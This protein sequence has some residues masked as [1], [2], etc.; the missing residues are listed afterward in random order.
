MLLSVDV[1]SGLATSAYA[2]SPDLVWR[3]S[4]L[5]QASQSAAAV[6]QTAVCRLDGDLLRSKLAAASPEFTPEAARGAL[7]MTVPTPDGRFAR[8]AIA[9]SPIMEPGLAAQFPAIAT[10]CG[11]GIDDPTA[12][13][14]FDV[15][16]AGFHAQVLAPSGDYYVDP[17]GT[18]GSTYLSYFDT[19]ARGAIGAAEPV[20]T[21]TDADF[22]PGP[23]TI[24]APAVAVADAPALISGT[25]LRTYR[26]AVAA[27]GEY[28][29]FQGGTVAAAQAAIVT[30]INRVDGIYERELSVRLTLVANNS[31]LVYTN[32]ATDPYTN[33][34]ASALLGE[35]QT[36]VDQVIG[37]ANY[38]I[39]HVFSTAGGGLAG[40]GVVGR[41]GWKA[42]GET[43]LSSPVGDA[44]YVDYVAH[45]M[46]H[47]FGA[48]HTFNGVN[49]A[50][51]GNRNAGTAYEPGSG[52]TIMS[53]AGICDA[54]DLQPHS[55]D[56]F[57]FASLDE[58]VGY[59]DGSVP[60]VGT[61]TPTGNAIPTV[62][63]GLN[64]TIPARTPFALTASGND[65]NGDTLTY[66]WEERDLGAAQSLS[67]GDNG[68][69][70]ILRSY[71]PTTDPTRTFPQ[72]SDL[73]D[74]T[75]S[76]GERLPTTSRT[77]NFRVTVRDNRS[78]GGG[79]NADDMKVT[80][81][82]TGAAFAVTSPTTAVSWNTGTAHTVTWNVAGTTGG[83]INASQVDI[84]LSTD[85]GNTF[86]IV[87]AAGTANDGSES[88]AV[89]GMASTSTARIMVRPVGNVFFAMSAADFSIVSVVNHAPV[90]DNTGLMMLSPVVVNDANSSGTLVSSII[91][92]AGG[93]RI[94]DANLDALEGIAVTAADTSHGAWQ[95]SI[96][97]GATWL[98]LG[99]PSEGSARMLAADAGTKVRFIP[100]TDFTGT[101]DPGITFH[102]W[103]QTS[104]AN[105]AVIDA[106][107]NGG[108]TSLS[109]AA[110]T[111]SVAV[112][113]DIASPTATLFDPAGGGTIQNAAINSRKTI[114]IAFADA[115]GSGLNSA[116]IVDSAPEFTLGGA[117]AARVV[118]SGTPT[119]VSENV[120]RYAFTGAFGVGPVSVGFIADS[121]KD[122]A[123]NGNLA[124]SV[125]FSVQPTLSIN[126]IALKEGNSG[127]SRFNFTVT[128]SARSA[129][130]ITV[131]YATQ[132]LTA[133]AGDDYTDT[134]GTLTF[135]AGETK[136]TVTVAVR[137]DWRYE[138]PETFAV[139][140]SDATGAIIAQGS[141][142]GTIRNDDAAPRVSIGRVQVTE[143][144]SGTT[145]AVFT[146]TLS[147]AS[148]RT[149][150]VHYATANGT[151]SVAEGDYLAATGNVTIPAGVTGGTITVQVN[152]DTLY[153]ADETFKVSLSA[154]DGATIARGKGTGT[155][156]I[157]ADGDVMPEVSIAYDSLTTVA[158][159][160]R[161]KF[162]VA[163]SAPSGLS[164]TVHYATVND[165]AKAGKDFKSTTGNL[166][167][168]AGQFQMPLYVTILGNPS[169]K[170]G[171]DFFVTLSSPK[172]ATLGSS[173]GT[174]VFR[175]QAAAV[176]SLLDALAASQR[177]T[178]QT[179]PQQH[180]SA[181]DEAIR[182]LMLTAR[183]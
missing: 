72:L 17:Y 150:T 96:N 103:D 116:T 167:I 126:S 15:T 84:L 113:T 129:E 5:A 92:S 39:G 142:I 122:N 151:A 21:V 75:T 135:A 83:G 16:P 160:T 26:L 85:G 95:F 6:A 111:A 173:T 170:D 79:I 117:A 133:S 31:S 93:D 89:P 114:D 19:G 49:G 53:Y 102:A 171:N 155:G 73:L 127:T 106:L 162:M 24:S 140:L 76:P 12:T 169:L 153:E 3:A 152:G 143:G 18:D 60:G 55:D 87:L 38:D 57:H 174:C 48:N 10:Y 56:V 145:D 77:L 183:P 35:N 33:G 154:P 36:N 105:G 99:S 163:L 118:V 115:G 134:N 121:V 74:N 144:D 119:L 128:L 157:L 178:S 52:S 147:A 45:E 139:N 20:G 8:F 7:Q 124:N 64:Y 146:V 91:A 181:V 86:P 104:G 141:G 100:D 71:A 130:T 34:D 166:T 14:R 159:V 4:D 123:G 13:L 107:V 22:L 172:R 29:R 101:V 28:T 70:P 23:S 44:F 43:G 40:L 59:L 182:L 131:N 98:A 149:T 9:E 90:L 25:Q 148:G 32:A 161:A 112:T 65:A 177:P 137:R 176:A 88:I 46:G 109:V 58:I 69:S 66:C 2:F 68:S 37:S 61:R 80:V 50:A 164:T 41:N 11:Q 120:W 138:N 168:A 47:Q 54:D 27:T 62:E 30:A 42:E 81:V 136:K 51:S 1:Q 94:S 78:G 97:G 67:A 180:G 125:S 110:A 165:T 82:N 108:S 158:N 156:T 175:T 63:A 179:G 132:A